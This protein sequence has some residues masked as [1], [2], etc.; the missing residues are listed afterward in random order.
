MLVE[1]GSGLST[2]VHLIYQE[3][4]NRYRISLIFLKNIVNTGKEDTEGH[5]ASVYGAQHFTTLNMSGCRYVS[6]SYFKKIF[7]LDKEDAERY[8]ASV[9]AQHFST[10]AKLNRGSLE[11]SIH[12]LIIFNLIEFST[13]RSSPNSFRLYETNYKNILQLQVS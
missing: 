2:L 1:L 6:A 7:F 8:A 12:I 11:S 4:D 9:G 3:V 5:A 10:S 13:F